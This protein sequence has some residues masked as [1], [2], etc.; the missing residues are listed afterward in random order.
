[1]CGAPVCICEGAAYARMVKLDGR[2]PVLVLGYSGVYDELA[3]QG[4]EISTSV[5]LMRPRIWGRWL[6]ARRR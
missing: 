3:S 4:H 2:G 1:M 6:Q 5:E